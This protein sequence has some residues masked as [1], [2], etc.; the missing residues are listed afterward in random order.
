MRDSG[1]TTGRRALLRTAGAALTTSVLP[2]RIL[3]ANDRIRVAFIG[4]GVMGTG[5]LGHFMKQPGTE[6]AA[7]CDV[8]QPNL[9]RAADLVR[10]GGQN[11]Q[12]VKDFRKILAD[13]SID[14]VCI[15]TPDHWHAYMTVEACKARRT[16]TS[17]S[18]SR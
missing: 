5:N 10:K 8:Y 16:C 15:S 12:V 17:R 9:E 2:H 6:V 4:T 13:K 18:R 1:E 14:A 7:V 3:A 11:P